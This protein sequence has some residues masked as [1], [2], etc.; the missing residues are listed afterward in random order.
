MT[1]I[2][3]PNGQQTY[4]FDEYGKEFIYPGDTRFGHGEP[5]KKKTKRQKPIDSEP[6][7]KKTKG[8]KS[9]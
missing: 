5:A 7:R 2:L 1:R 8:E 9:S 4:D 6:A 3:I